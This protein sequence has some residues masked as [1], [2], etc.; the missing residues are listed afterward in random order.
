MNPIIII[1]ARLAASRLPG[2]PLALIGGRPMILH[3]LDRAREARVGPVAVAAGDPEIV[4]VVRAAGGTA[5]LTDPNL[6]S[7]SDRVHAALGVLDP[8]RTH[9]VII[10]LQG[11]LPSLPPEYIKAVLEPLRD[12]T[13]DIGT[14]VAPIKSPSEAAADSVVKAACAFADNARIAPVPYFSRTAVPWGSGPLWHHIGI[15]AWRRFAL[16]RF[17]AMPPSPL[18]LR[19]KLEQLRALEAGMRIAAARVPTAPFGVD[20][21]EDLENARA[22]YSK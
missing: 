20:T 14:L 17:V 22:A 9:D 5:V 21:P 2:K 18:E 11:D 7:G 8:D 1:P 6:P 13:I 10:N 4:D 19:E 16:T 3:V 12:Q 15:Y